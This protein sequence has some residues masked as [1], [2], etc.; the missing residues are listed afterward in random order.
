[1]HPLLRN[2][3]TLAVYLPVWAALA[4]ALA[5]LLRVPSIMSWRDALLLSGL[6]S[7]VLAVLCLGP[8]YTCRPL[9]L[10]STKRWQLAYN[11]GGA[12]ILVTAFFIACSR[13]I[14]SSLKIQLGPEM[15]ILIA[16]SLLLY[17]LSV[18]I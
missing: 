7:M 3:T 4:L 9:P 11:H 16:L 6:L 13:G 14:S 5:A 15:P 2:R 8:W 1:M 18:A 10:G 12:A 17:Y